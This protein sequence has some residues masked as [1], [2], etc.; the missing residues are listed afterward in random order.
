MR[1]GI[2]KGVFPFIS[3][4]IIKIYNLPVFGWFASNNKGMKKKMKSKGRRVRDNNL[5]KVSK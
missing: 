2:K 1:M 3:L 4:K 5:M